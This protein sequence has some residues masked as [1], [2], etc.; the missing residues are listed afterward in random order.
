MVSFELD[1]M[2]GLPPYDG[3]EEMGDANT[4]VVY[5]Q[6]ARH[7]CV[8]SRAL[9]WEIHVLVRFETGYLRFARMAEFN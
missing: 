4:R 8:L 9:T 7:L 5:L 3:D 1:R 2:R 6:R